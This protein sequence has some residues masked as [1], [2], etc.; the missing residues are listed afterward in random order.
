VTTGTTGDFHEN[1]SLTNFTSITLNSTGYMINSSGPFSDPVS[2]L[3]G[4]TT[5]VFACSGGCN[6]LTFTLLGTLSSLDFSIGGQAYHASSLN[7]TSPGFNG[8]FNGSLNITVE[9]APIAATP[10][11]ATSLLV[12]AGLPFYL[13]IRRRN[14]WNH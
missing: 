4:A 10:E 11:S 2:V 9:A 7:W 14:G 8:A 3:A 5:N 13:V 1:T 12:G 6:T